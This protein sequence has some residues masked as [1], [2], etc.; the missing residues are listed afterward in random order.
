MLTNET[1]FQASASKS[2]WVG[3][4]VPLFSLPTPFYLLRKPNHK[5]KNNKMEI[6]DNTA[7]KKDLYVPTDAPLDFKYK[8]KSKAA[9]ITHQIIYLS[10]FA[11]GYWEDDFVPLYSQALRKI[12]GGS[13]KKYIDELIGRGVIEKGKLYSTTDNSSTKYAIAEEYRGDFGLWTCKDEKLLSRLMEWK[14]SQQN[15]YLFWQNEPYKSVRKNLEKTE[16]DYLRAFDWIRKNDNLTGAQKDYYKAIVKRIKDGKNNVSVNDTNGRIQNPVAQMPKKLRSFLQVGG[17]RKLVES[18]V[19][20]SQPFFF[21]A[22][23]QAGRKRHSPPPSPS[24]LM[25]HT[26]F[27]TAAKNGRVYERLADEHGIDREEAKSITFRVLFSRPNQFKD[28]KSKFADAFPEAFDFAV[29]YKRKHGHNQLAIDAQQMES[30]VMLSTLE[31]LS[32][33]GIWALPVFDAVITKPKHSDRAKKLFL[34]SFEDLEP[35]IKTQTL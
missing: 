7:T 26:P 32:D 13:Y 11:P 20:N 6:F 2:V 16:I 27:T 29:D 35:T 25:Y 24:S 3:G 4:S 10:T 34:D 30:E 31:K 14:R 1:N 17:R 28:M 8:K 22:L 23:V 18:D 9:Y 21:A 15:S 33:E 5:T 12:V 19:V